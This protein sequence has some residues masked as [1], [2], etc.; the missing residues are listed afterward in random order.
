MGRMAGQIAYLSGPMDLV[1]DRG[2]IWRREA[3]PRLV[4]LNIGGLDPLNKPMLGQGSEDESF[5]I[6]RERLFNVAI[7]SGELKDR[8]AISDFMKSQVVRPDLGMVDYAHF[9]IVYIDID[10]HL[11]GTYREF[12]TAIMQRKPCLVFCKQGLFNIPKWWWG[13]A[14]PALFFDTIDD[15]F[16]YLKWVD[17]TTE[18]LKFWRFFDIE[19]VYGGKI[20]FVDSN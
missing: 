1:P 8:L 2:E 10:V 19:K 5:L 11:A 4:D 12:T 17:T 9:L 16:D 18:P 13:D 6:E 14:N 20:K 7:K 15:I 3:T